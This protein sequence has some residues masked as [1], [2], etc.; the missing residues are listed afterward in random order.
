MAEP[1]RPTV[2][3]QDAGFQ[4][5]ALQTLFDRIRREVDEGRMPH[6]QL[7]F[8]VDGELAVYEAFGEATTSTRFHVFSCTKALIAGVVWQLIGEGRL[9]PETRA[10]E[11]VPV[12]GTEGSTPDRMAKVTL[13]HLL[14]HTSGFPYA[15]LGPPDWDSRESRLAKLARWNAAFEPGT[16]FEYHP[17]AAHWVVAEIIEVLEGRDFRQVVRER[18]IEP[19]GLQSFGL[20]LTELDDH[21]SIAELAMVGELPTPEEIEQVFGTAEVD[22]GEVT[23]AILLAFNDRNIR[24]VGVPGGGGV[25]TAADLALYYQALLHDPKG[26]WDPDVL[27]DGTGHIRCRLPNPQTGVASNR[28]LGLIIAGD[29]GLG[30]FRGMGPTVSPRAFGHNGAGGQ[31]AWADPATGVSFAFTTS[32]LELNFIR[33]AKRIASIAA[34]AGLGKPAEA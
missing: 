25:A 31:I 2:D 20:G 15:P 10:I 11:L 1:Y 23:P 33:E 27:S 6:A 32:A 34:K 16:H 9:S 5:V 24:R 28:S 18:I 8:A 17:T 21:D 14:T 30:A 4:P 29:D 22:L 7:A 3:P 12:L 13:E 26:M 19:L